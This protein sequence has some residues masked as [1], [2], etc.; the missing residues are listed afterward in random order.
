MKK[1]GEFFTI[2]REHFSKA[3]RLGDEKGWLG[4][5]I[6]YLVLAKST[7]ATQRVSTAG[8]NAIELH[9]GLFRSRAT[10]IL[11]VF[12]EQGIV[13]PLGGTRGA[14]TYEL[15]FNEA[16]AETW[17]PNA[18]VDGSGKTASPLKSIRETRKLAVLE[19]FLD[20]FDNI[21]NGIGG[22]SLDLLHI[23]IGATK[24]RWPV[25]LNG[26]W[27]LW[28]FTENNTLGSWKGTERYTHVKT[29]REKGLL[30]NTV[31]VF[32]DDGPDEPPLFSMCGTANKASNERLLHDAISAM[33]LPRGPWLIPLTSK[34]ESPILRVVIRPFALAET[35]PMLNFQRERS[36]VAKALLEE[37]LPQAIAAI[38]NHPAAKSLAFHNGREMVK[39]SLARQLDAIVKDHEKRLSVVE[40][41]TPEEPRYEPPEF[42]RKKTAV[43]TR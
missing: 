35:I 2:R 3:C 1:A 27:N 36:R 17:L 29:L 18:I 24:E 5:G 14:P 16:D 7:N 28:E 23:H 11:S 22:L 25:P 41:A 30:H 10:K 4:N 33:S 21:E 39:G 20:V 26:E 8:V 31:S 9:G 40:P 34:Y 15:L 6:A 43:R 37:N 19:T 32:G 42:L 38:E 12:A 13:R